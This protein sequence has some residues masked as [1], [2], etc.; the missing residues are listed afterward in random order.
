LSLLDSACFFWNVH[1]S[2]DYRYASSLSEGGF[3][4]KTTVQ[5]DVPLLETG[6][7]IT[8]VDAR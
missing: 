3:S 7:P 2:A 8:S 4:V 5:D 1:A 6:K